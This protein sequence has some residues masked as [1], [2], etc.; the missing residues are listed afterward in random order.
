MTM[1][2]TPYTLYTTL[3]GAYSSYSRDNLKHTRDLTISNM[4]KN[5]EVDRIKLT[6]KTISKVVHSRKILLRNLNKIR[7]FHTNSK[8]SKWVIHWDI[9]RYIDE[10]EKVFEY[11]FKEYC[12]NMP[13]GKPY[14]KK[15]FLEN[16]LSEVP[17]SK[18]YLN[19]FM[20]YLET[21]QA[22]DKSL[23]SLAIHTMKHYDALTL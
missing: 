4:I 20:N 19:E 3:H 13:D 21:K 1:H 17:Y 23:L 16:L 10:K 15:L 12:Q 2:K 22:T 18:D 11:Y 7:D 9:R 14:S 6:I 5:Q 8:F